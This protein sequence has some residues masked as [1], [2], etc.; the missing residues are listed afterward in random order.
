MKKV[1][2]NV[3]A[4]LVGGGLALLGA[5]LMALKPSD[6]PKSEIECQRIILKNPQ[7]QVAIELDARSLVPTVKMFDKNG[8]LQIEMLVA[9]SPSIKMK[10]DKQNDLLCLNIDRE[11]TPV[12]HLEDQGG[13]S[14]LQMQGGMSP[15]LFL[16]NAENEVIGTMLTLQDGGAAVGLADNDGD[17]ATF[18]RGGS[19]PS[20]CFFQKSVEPL[21]AIGISQNVPHLLVTSPTTKD[22]LILHGG[23]PTSMLF[24]DDKGDVAILLSKHGLFQGKKETSSPQPSGEEKLFTLQEFL[25][26]LK[27]IKLKRS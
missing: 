24:L 9:E 5:S 14:R 13:R 21:T 26:P 16:R 11:G 4:L 10:G 22:N 8:R 1:Q 19:N 18:M 27:D 6:S 15:A 7:G 23:E 3:A 17:V 25:N 20:I 12:V 2:N